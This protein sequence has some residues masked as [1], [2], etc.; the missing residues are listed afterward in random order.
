MVTNGNRIKLL[1]PVLLPFV[2]FFVFFV[3]LQIQTFLK[4]RDIKKV[5]DFINEKTGF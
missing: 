3:I 1:K 4:V 5:L 2:T